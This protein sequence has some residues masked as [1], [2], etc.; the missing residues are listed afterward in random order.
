MSGSSLSVEGEDIHEGDI[1]DNI[2]NVKCANAHLEMDFERATKYLRGLVG[3]AQQEDLL[4]F[5]ARFKQ[6]TLGRCNV[7]KP[8]FYQLKEKSKWNAWNDL[9]D[10][11]R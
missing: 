7:P 8:S 6:V 11:S 10:K 9:G 2:F 3:S 4:Y 5:Y 1:V